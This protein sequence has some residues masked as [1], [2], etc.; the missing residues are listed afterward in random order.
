MRLAGTISRYSNSAI[1]QLASAAI[2][3]GLAESSFRCAYQAKVMKTF[4]ANSRPA[5]V[6]IG[7]NCMSVDPFDELVRAAREKFAGRSLARNLRA[8][9]KFQE[10]LED[11]SAFVHARMG[12]RQA[13]PRD[14]FLAEQEEVEIERP[15]RIGK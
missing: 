11:E 1:P 2:H 10:R 4:D 6:A 3:Q 13:G 9:S 15:R 8:R 12:H 14:L 5:E 7:E